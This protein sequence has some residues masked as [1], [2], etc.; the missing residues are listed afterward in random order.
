MPT[1]PI[2]GDT[3]PNC[4]APNQYPDRPKVDHSL[5]YPRNRPTTYACGTVASPNW[6]PPVYDKNCI[7]KSDELI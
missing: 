1:H 6:S 4:G 2:P 7:A 5:G 3:C